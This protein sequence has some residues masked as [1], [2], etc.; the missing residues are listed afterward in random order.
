[1]NRFVADDRAP[2]GNGKVI[3]L[4]S[5]DMDDT[6]SWWINSLEPDTRERYWAKKAAELV[7]VEA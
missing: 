7:G 1:M 5:P 3:A 4:S 2:I 6:G